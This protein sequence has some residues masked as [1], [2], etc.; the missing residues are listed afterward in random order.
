MIDFA[1]LRNIGVCPA[2]MPKGTKILNIGDCAV[3]HK[4]FLCIS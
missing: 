1:Y 4:H 3:L 2:E